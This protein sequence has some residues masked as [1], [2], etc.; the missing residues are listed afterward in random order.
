MIAETESKVIKKVELKEKTSKIKTLKMSW[1]KIK[2]LSKTQTFKRLGI[3]LLIMTILSLYMISIDY[4]LNECFTL[5]SK[6]SLDLSVVK[7]IISVVFLILAIALITLEI[8]RK[9]NTKGFFV[10]TKRIHTTN[11]TYTKLI[12]IISICLFILLIA[13]YIL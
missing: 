4:G 1:S 2:F 8:F 6:V 11:D 9:S 5:L 7:T 13:M 12:R 10:P 3:V